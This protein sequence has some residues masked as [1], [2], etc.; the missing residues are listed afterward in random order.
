MSW[1][2]MVFNFHGDPPADLSCLPDDTP[3][4]TLGPAQAVRDAIA[5]TLPGVDWSDPHWGLYEGDGFSL[6]FNAGTRDPLV[7]LMVHVRGGG[8]AI[9]ALLRFA[10][11]HQ[12]S[13]F[14]CSTGEFI[15]PGEPSQTGW[16]GFQAYRDLVIKR[17]RT[18]ENP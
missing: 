5:R 13:L 4:E 16:E 2:V 7:A 8:D 12:W 14:D 15:D 1:D 3:L 18:A 9:A 10:M 17:H 6:E 11:P